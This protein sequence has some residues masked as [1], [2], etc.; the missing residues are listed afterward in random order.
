MICLK[1][2]LFIVSRLYPN[3]PVCSLIY[4]LKKPV[5]STGKS[6]RSGI[7]VFSSRI[8]HDP[9]PGPGM[10]KVT[11]N[12]LITFTSMRLTGGKGHSLRKD[13]YWCHLADGEMIY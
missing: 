11:N 5:N 12:H 8:F 9:V 6:L 1:Y 13:V 7:C 2:V 3:K 10:Q 4:L